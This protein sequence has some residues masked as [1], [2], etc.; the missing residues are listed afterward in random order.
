MA[1]GLLCLLSCQKKVQSNS[2]VTHSPDQFFLRCRN[3][4]C[5]TIVFRIDT[6]NVLPLTINRIRYV[7]YSRRKERVIETLMRIENTIYGVDRRGRD[8][9]LIK[10]IDLSASQIDTCYDLTSKFINGNM[11][12]FKVP[13]QGRI[14]YKGLT[15]IRYDSTFVDA[16]VY[17]I[18]SPE[19]GEYYYYSSELWFVGSR[20]VFISDTTDLTLVKV[21]R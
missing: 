1:S 15:K 13:S 21:V 2:E 6:L 19:G 11:P 4:K 10:F 18:E 14:C 17:F 5:D 7:D 9:L 12:R 16:R 3:G 20:R 8:T